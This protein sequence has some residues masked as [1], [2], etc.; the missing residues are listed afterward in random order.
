MNDTA[1]RNN[2]QHL[3]IKNIYKLGNFYNIH[4]FINIRERL[5]E[6]SMQNAGFNFGKNIPINEQIAALKGQAVNNPSEA[7][8]K[9]AQT[10][11]IFNKQSRYKCKTSY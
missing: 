1:C 3:K 9:N 6:M 10:S 4:V 11:S 5:R 2:C 7:I 8:E